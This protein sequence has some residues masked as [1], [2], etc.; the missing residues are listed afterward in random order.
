[1]GIEKALRG[2]RNGGRKLL[3]PYVMGGMTDDWVEVVQAVVA[4][5]ADAVEVGI[6]FS[7][8]MMDGPVIQEASVL[9]LQRGTTPQAVSALSIT[10]P[11]SGA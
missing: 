9:A 3:V 8:P 2:A 4:A 5:G 7:D 1:M 11:P 10:T 6:P